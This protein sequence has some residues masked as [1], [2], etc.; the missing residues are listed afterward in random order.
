MFNLKNKLQIKAIQ[1]YKIERERE[2]KKGWDVRRRKEW[3]QRGVKFLK[4]P[5]C[6]F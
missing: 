5:Q 1:L 3:K 2:K 4:P 6:V